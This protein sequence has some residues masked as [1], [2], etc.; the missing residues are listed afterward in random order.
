MDHMLK[1]I[2]WLGE[3]KISENKI[4]SLAYADDSVVMTDS[5]DSL[6]SNISE[7]DQRCNSYGMKISISKTKVTSVRKRF[8]QIKCQIGGTKL[9]QADSFKYLAYI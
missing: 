5:I 9:E 3:I 4:S 8:K 6:Q 7:Q 2:D 1:S